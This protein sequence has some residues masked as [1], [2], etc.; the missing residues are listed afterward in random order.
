[1]KC[2]LRRDDAQ[3]DP[4]LV[5]NKFVHLLA[6]SEAGEL[7]PAQRPAHLAFCYDSEVQNGGHQQYFENCPTELVGDTISALVTLGAS[8]Q[9]AVL[10]SASDRWM[11]KHR[12]KP[13][14]AAE[15]VEESL[16][17]EFLD[18]DATYYALS[19]SITDL[20]ERFL[21]S[22]RGSFVDFIG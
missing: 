22:N 15:Y 6:F 9:A 1:M 13:T 10:K 19:P 7:D 16:D 3:R 20:L 8:Q 12:G 17:M 11:S 5:W 14:T 21:E 18:L 4:N 2:V